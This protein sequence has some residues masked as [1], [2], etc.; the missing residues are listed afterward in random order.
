[1]AAFTEDESFVER[2]TALQAESIDEQ[3]DVFSRR[4]VFSLGDRYSEVFDL[5]TA[6]TAAC[7]ADEGAETLSMAG[8]ANF[9]QQNGKTRT[10]I[11]RRA[12]LKDVDLNQDGRCSFIEYLLLHYKIMILEEYFRRHEMEPDVEMDNDGVGVTGVGERLVQEL[13]SVP[14]GVDPE[15]EKMMRE[16]SIEHAK[17]KAKIAELE[18]KVAA[19]GVKG[20]AAKN[21]LEQLMLE[22]QSSMHAIEARITAAVKKAVSKANK[23]LAAKSIAADADAEAKRVAGRGKLAEKMAMFN[24]RVSERLSLGRK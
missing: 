11:Q 22:D 16:F 4:F 6:F 12:E 7:A 19:G 3:R 14:Q 5:A 13:F 18:A 2:F 21:T 9:L 24:K 20:M 8:A 17:R 23:E 1:M 15:L 10:A